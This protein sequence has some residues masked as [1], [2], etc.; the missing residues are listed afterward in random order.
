MSKQLKAVQLQLGLDPELVEIL[1]GAPDPTLGGG[2][3]ADVGSL[4]LRTTGVLYVKTGVGNT[5][6]SSFGA[7]NAQRFTYVADGSEGSSWSISLPAAR[8]NTN[9][10]VFVSQ[11]DMTAAL[12]F[13]TPTTGR[14]VNAFPIQTSSAVTAGDTFEITVIDPT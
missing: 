5:A 1:A 4:Y 3:A 14:T 6:W 8:A 10:L 12:A 9:Y 11:A 2:V 13:I 7:G